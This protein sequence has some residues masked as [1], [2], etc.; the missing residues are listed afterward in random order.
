MDKPQLEVLLI[1][2]TSSAGEELQPKVTLAYSVARPGTPLGRL[3]SE[4]FDHAVDA[5]KAP[6]NREVVFTLEEGVGVGVGKVYGDGFPWEV[7]QICKGW[8]KKLKRFRT[9]RAEGG[10]TT[11]GKN[12]CHLEGQESVLTGF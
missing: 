10:G 1:N 11:F 8:M 9:F 6:R 12:L 4:P 7:G 5:L 3:I 2:S